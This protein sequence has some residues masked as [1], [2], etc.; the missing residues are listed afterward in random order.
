[1]KCR[2]KSTNLV[3]DGIASFWEGDGLLEVIADLFELL[4][5]GPAVEGAS[6]VHLLSRVRPAKVSKPGL[7]DSGGAQSLFET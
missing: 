7:V 5:L 4:A 2:R 6:N 1:M 3:E